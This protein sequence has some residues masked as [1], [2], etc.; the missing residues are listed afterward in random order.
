MSFL[1]PTNLLSLISTD[2]VETL[3]TTNS[4]G[5][6]ALWNLNERVLIGQKVG[7]HAGKIQSVFF[8]LGQPNMVTCGSDNKMARWFMETEISMPVASKLIEGHNGEITSIR[9]CTDTSIISA[10]IDGH[11][12]SFNIYRGDKIA[13]LGVAREVK[14]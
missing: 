4:E 8:L 1:L 5:T 14:K 12:R 11:V 2:G 10:G 7:A 13:Q 9:F 3:A 6:I